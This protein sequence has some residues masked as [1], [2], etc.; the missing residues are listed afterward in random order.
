MNEW[1]NRSIK[2]MS[3]S[4]YIHVS[5]R[6][7]LLLNLVKKKSTKL[8]NCYEIFV[9]VLCLC[10]IWYGTRRSQSCSIA[11]KNIN[12]ANIFVSWI[13]CFFV[14]KHSFLL[15]TGFYYFFK[16][17]S[18]RFYLLNFLKHTNFSTLFPSKVLNWSHIFFN[19]PRAF[20]ICQ[21]WTSPTSKERN[22]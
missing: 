13:G 15:F 17:F 1:L 20:F 10:T 5:P 14:L 9:K 22:G 18:N 7:Y 3:H 6:K 4:A 16:Y 8:I 21:T 11:Q 19:Q 2:N 12:I